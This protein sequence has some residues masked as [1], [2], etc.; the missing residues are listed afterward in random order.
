MAIVTR[1]EVHKLKEAIKAVDFEVSFY[2]QRIK[3]VDG[4]IVK[5]KKRSLIILYQM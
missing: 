3:E 5:R 4:G 1:L 2:V